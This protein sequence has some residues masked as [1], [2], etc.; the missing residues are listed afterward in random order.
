MAYITGM[1][2]IFVLGIRLIFVLGK[3]LI[4]M[5]MVIIVKNYVENDINSKL[6]SVSF[7]LLIF[8]LSSLTLP[9]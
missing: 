3:K 4:S 1:K 9:G 8:N 5:L 6:I 2:L 7:S